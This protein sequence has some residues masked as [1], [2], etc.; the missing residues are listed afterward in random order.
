M[1][2]AEVQ[3]FAA[4]ELKP[5]DASL[6]VV[7]DGKL[8]LPTLRAKVPNLEVIPIAEFEPDNATLK[9]SP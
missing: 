4:A 9:A 7:G 6:I 2:P 3:A 5:V 8:F 1:T